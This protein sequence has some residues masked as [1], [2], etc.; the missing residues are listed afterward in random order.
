M[1][2]ARAAHT[3][4]PARWGSNN[5]PGNPL[6]HRGL[7]GCD[8]VGRRDLARQRSAPNLACAGL[9]GDAPG[10]QSVVEPQQIRDSLQ[11]T[12]P[13]AA[14]HSDYDSLANRLHPARL[15][16][17]H[18]RGKAYTVWLPKRLRAHHDYQ[19]DSAPGTIRDVFGRALA[20]DLQ[21]RPHRASPSP[22]DPRPPAH[23]LTVLEQPVDTDVAPTRDQSQTGRPALP[24][25]ERRWRDPARARPLGLRAR[26]RQPRAPR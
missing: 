2:L 25:P 19:V 16:V 22:A 14:G 15:S 3:R 12:P 26:Y 11:L 5:S 1:A 20:H 9:A 8:R 17:P 7:R 24:N 13:L 4:L 18:R 6:S 10:F 23:S 21:M